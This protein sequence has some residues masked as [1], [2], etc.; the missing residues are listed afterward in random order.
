M[1]RYIFVTSCDC[2]KASSDLRHGACAS[3]CVCTRLLFY[4]RAQYLLTIEEIVVAVSIKKMYYLY[5]GSRSVRCS[6]H[7]H[8]ADGATF[9]W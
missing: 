1:L 9:G 2:E 8:G 7:I 5:V 4:L 3:E 6:M